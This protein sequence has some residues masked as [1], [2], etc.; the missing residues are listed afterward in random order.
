M[1]SEYTPET[2]LKQAGYFIDDS[3]VQQM[4]HAYAATLRQQAGRVDAALD[5]QL[6]A[7]NN[8]ATR[9][10]QILEAAGIADPRAALTAALAQNTTIPNVQDFHRPEDGDDYAPAFRRALAQNTQGDGEACNVGGSWLWCKLMDWCK[11]RR[12]PPAE[13]SDLF[14]IAGEAHKLA[15]APAAPADGDGKEVSR[16]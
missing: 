16:G 12:V 7:A 10:W 4:L 11:K 13:Y 15:A 3:P 9:V 1:G 14:A 8:D 5:A 6:L 2:V